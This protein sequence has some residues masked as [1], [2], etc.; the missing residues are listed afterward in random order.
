[1]FE[2]YFLVVMLTAIIVVGR[3]VLLGPILGVSL[4]LAQQNFLS[5]GGDGNKVAL[6]VV[7]VAIL[8]GWP[9]GL[10]GLAD[11]LRNRISTRK[12]AT[13]SPE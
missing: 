9:K 8:V 3:R 7:L 5:I 4:I 6:G 13:G 2:T 12:G 10:V 11:Y 1:M